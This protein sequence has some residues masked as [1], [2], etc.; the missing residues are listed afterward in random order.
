MPHRRAVSLT[1]LGMSAALLLAACGDGESADDPAATGGSGDEVTLTWWHNS[2]NDPGKSVYEQVAADFEADNP[3][4][5]IEI[6]ALAHEDMLTRLDAAFQ[7]GDTPDIYM[8]RGGGELAAHVEAGLV[9]DLSDVASDTIETLGGNVAGW[10][11]DG[12]TYAL[13]F[14]VGLVGF[15]YNTSL[16]EEAGITQPPTTMEEFYEAVDALKAA[17]IEPVSVGAGDKWPAAHYWYYLSL[18]MC[19]EDVISTAVTELDFSDPCFVAAGEELERLIAAEP[20]NTGFLATPA[21]TGPTSAS[22]LLATGQ[23]AMELA[24]H[25]EPGVMQGLTEDNQGLGEDTGWFTFPAVEGGQGDP[26][27]ALGGG[28]AWACSNDAPDICV[29]FIQYL[30]SDEVQQTFAEIDMGL[31]TNPAAID[32]VSDPA[33]ADLLTIRDQAPY[34]QLYFDTLFGENIGGAMN[35]EIALVFAGQSSP[36]GIVDAT[37]AAAD[38]E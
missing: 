38:L 37:Q 27:A 26:E 28:D 5:T 35:D 17:G 13:P 29:E 6:S 19:S 2:N 16:F 30:L 1:A 31:P 20:F 3:G 9:K 18:R 23:V 22:G 10:Q 15:W 8:E 32:F 12:R 24:G 11:V 21:Q 33:L 34:V 25:W 4:L 14:S 36:Q 7:T